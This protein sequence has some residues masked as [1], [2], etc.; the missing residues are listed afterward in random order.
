MAK[1]EVIVS[2]LN[3]GLNKI[4]L[5]FVSDDFNLLVIHQVSEE[6]HYDY[7]R[8]FS[9]NVRVI[10]TRELGLSKSRNLA[11]EHAEAEF[12]LLSDDDMIY[13]KDKLEEVYNCFEQGH[14]L[15]TF[16]IMNKDNKPF[17]C[18][19]RISKKR[20]LLSYS[21]CSCEM[22]FRTSF[23]RGFSYDEDFGLGS[24]YPA[25]EELIILYDIL[26]TSSGSFYFCDK[27]LALHFDDT[28]TSLKINDEYC[29][30]FGAFLNRTNSNTFFI[31]IVKFSIGNFIRRRNLISS[32]KIIYLSFLGY[33]RYKK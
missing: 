14:D 15:V 25:F 16:K 2:T 3:F 26:S 12:I 20:R 21:F 19:P 28:H 24:K 33:A 27:Y 6:L 32:L 18:Y 9:P 11:I 8:F 7:S 30:A 13:E 1:L 23:I 29:L 5:G 4:D 10:V 22:A 31:K 17:R